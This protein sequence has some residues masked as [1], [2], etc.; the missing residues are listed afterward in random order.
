MDALLKRK[1]AEP[2]LCFG[3]LHLQLPWISVLGNVVLKRKN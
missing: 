2:L 3:P 1:I